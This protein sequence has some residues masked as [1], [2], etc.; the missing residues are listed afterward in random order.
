MPNIKT[1][2]NSHNKKIIKGKDKKEIK[3]CNCKKFECP[4]K[5]SK[6]SCRQECVVYEAK[7]ESKN[8]TKYY[9]GLTENEFKKRYYGHRLDFANK[10]KANSTALSQYIWDLKGK[11]EDYQISWKILKAVTKLK[12]GNKM[13]RL[14]VTEAATIMKGTKGQLNR[15]TEILNK[16][17]HQNK[18]LLKKLER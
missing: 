3:K 5:N 13:C 1:I 8:E 7:V 4:M 10:T 14:C 2:I 17:R 11:K 9:I 16:C 15:R 6:T 18:Y 12:N